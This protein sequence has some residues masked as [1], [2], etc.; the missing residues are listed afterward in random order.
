MCC[1]VLV[2]LT[3]DSWKSYGPRG[4]HNNE[5][6]WL[7]YYHRCLFRLY[8]SL[9][10]FTVEWWSWLIATGFFMACTWGAKVNGILTVAT[11]GI[12]VLVDLW[13]ILDHKKGFTMT[14]SRNHARYSAMLDLRFGLDAVALIKLLNLT[15][16]SDQRGCRSG[17]STIDMSLKWKKKWTNSILD[18][19][20]YGELPPAGAMAQRRPSRKSDHQTSSYSFS[21][22][23][24]PNYN[25]RLNHNLKLRQTRMAAVTTTARTSVTPGVPVI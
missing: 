15:L 4:L 9:W 14:L 25:L 8:H 13:D 1:A 6:N 23:C 12:A 22:S 5:G 24:N 20:D 18:T 11:I 7:L 3:H 21:K 2:M 16:T 17:G 10:E 19:W